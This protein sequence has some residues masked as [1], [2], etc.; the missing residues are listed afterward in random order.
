MKPLASKV[1]QLKY[2]S[3]KPVIHHRFIDYNNRHVC[4]G[5]LLSEGDPR[6]NIF[7]TISCKVFKIR[8]K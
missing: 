2:N 7:N 5:H 6:L 1:K 8:K 4:I 3:I